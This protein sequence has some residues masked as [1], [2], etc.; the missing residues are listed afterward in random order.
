MYSFIK[1]ISFLIR[2]FMLPNPFSNIFENHG[3]AFIINTICGGIFI[4]LAY[5]LTG[6]WYDGDW[7]LLGSIGFLI[8][9]SILTCLFL[10]ITNFISN[11]WIAII[12]FLCLFVL[13]GIFE[14]KLFGKKYLF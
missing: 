5:I 1:A 12:L 13:F 4:F 8:N 7:A 3:I 9:F 14:N 2:Q 6:T 10:L 11:I